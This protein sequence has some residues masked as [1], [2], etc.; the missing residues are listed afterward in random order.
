MAQR[1]KPNPRY[2]S[3]MTPGDSIRLDCS[4]KNPVVDTST[5]ATAEP[6]AGGDG[7]GKGGGKDDGKGEGKDVG[8]V[9]GKDDGKGGGKDAGK[10]G[11]KDDGKGKG[12][13]K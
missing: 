11:G 10:G 8:K 5:P 4:K 2:V 12:K 1:D 7:K 6:A 3:L 9:G 13:G